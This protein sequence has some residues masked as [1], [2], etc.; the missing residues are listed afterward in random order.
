M[1]PQ[2]SCGIL[3][4]QSAR[5]T[6]SMRQ[7]HIR[8][9]DGPSSPEPKGITDNILTQPAI[10]AKL[11]T[12]AAWRRNCPVAVNCLPSRCSAAAH[13][14]K[15][16]HSWSPGGHAKRAPAT[17]GMHPVQGH[18]SGPTSLAAGAIGRPP[19]I[20]QRTRLPVHCRLNQAVRMHRFSPA[21]QPRDTSRPSHRKGLP[22]DRGTPDNKS[23]MRC[24]PP[25]QPA[26]VSNRQRAMA[27]FVLPP[28]VGPDL[29]SLS[30]RSNSLRR[31]RFAS[32]PSAQGPSSPNKPRLAAT[33]GLH[34]LPHPRPHDPLLRHACRLRSEDHP[35][36]SARQRAQHGGYHVVVAPRHH[37]VP[38]PP[39]VFPVKVH[40]HVPHP[41]LTVQFEHRLTE[42]PGPAPRF[43]TSR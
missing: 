33:D 38:V 6:T 15:A 27:S 30:L 34:I 22:V 32:T 36:H 9:H 13:A 4:S 18:D 11:A 24:K 7:E 19:G 40:L 10:S 35:G 1:K 2:E 41:H 3:P 42:S 25:S 12:P 31:I 43:Q 8:P 20:P 5:Q 16:T 28:P 23:D 39:P 17:P 21:G 14:S 37:A 26:N 29:R